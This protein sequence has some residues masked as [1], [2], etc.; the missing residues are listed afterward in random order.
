MLISGPRSWSIPT[1]ASSCTPCTASI[2]CGR[3]T[4]MWQGS[5]HSLALPAPAFHED[6]LFHA[7][8]FLVQIS[9][10][11]VL[12]FGII[13]AQYYLVNQ[14]SVFVWLSLHPAKY[15]LTCLFELFSIFKPYQSKM[16][17]IVFDAVI[18]ICIER[19]SLWSTTTSLLWIPLITAHLTYI[20]CQL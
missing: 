8:L 12:R 2:S 10:F 17:I 18:M 3:H 15:V 4:C 14:K 13:N 11:R 16:D 19:L 1:S 9:Y 7:S 6:L 20:K 5:H